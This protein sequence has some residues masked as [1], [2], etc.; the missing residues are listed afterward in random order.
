MQAG[1]T[2][3][4]TSSN[5]FDLFVSVNQANINVIYIC[6]MSNEL[7]FVIGEDNLQNVGV[8]FPV[9]L[10]IQLKK[11]FIQPNYGNTVP[12]ANGSYD[13][14]SS[15]AATAASQFYNSPMG[16]AMMPIKIALS[17]YDSLTGLNGVYKQAVFTISLL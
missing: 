8:N 4:T 5:A 12:N 6:E 1:S 10:S 2:A 7:T 13:F 9:N 3:S 17:D 15:I 11:V 14:T 16:T